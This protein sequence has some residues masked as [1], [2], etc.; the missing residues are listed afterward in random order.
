MAAANIDLDVDTVPAVIQDVKAS[1]LEID[2]ER[3]KSALE[4]MPDEFRLVVLMFYFED[5]SYKEIAAQLEIP[6]G[7]V[8]SRLSRAKR[9]LRQCLTEREQKKDAKTRQRGQQRPLST[10]STNLLR[11]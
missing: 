2:E 10:P 7:T 5:L 8:M 9:R 3:L 4:A 1:D 6:M 11:E